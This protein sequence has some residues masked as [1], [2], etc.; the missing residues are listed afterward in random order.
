MSKLYD[1]Y[2]FLKANDINSSNTLYIFKSGIFFILLEN[3]AKI[4]SK[5]LDLKITYFTENV[6]KC[7]FPINSLKKYINI[8]ERT[9]YN[10]KIIDNSK[11]INY[12]IDDYIINDNIEKLLSKISTIDTNT[13]SVKE[14]Y[15]F[16]ET[17]KISAQYIMRKDKSNENQ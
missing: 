5:I 13:L 6:V 4:A 10:F 3:D 9:Q 8:L 17:I 7:G 11:N 14:A 2:L 12:S 16:I 1:N 15:N